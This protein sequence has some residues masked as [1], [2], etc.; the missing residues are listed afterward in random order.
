MKHPAA[1]GPDFGVQVSLKMVNSTV[2]VAIPARAAIK[3]KWGTEVTWIEDTSGGAA[4]H[5]TFGRA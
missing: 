3:A 5:G 1:P 2:E 4:P